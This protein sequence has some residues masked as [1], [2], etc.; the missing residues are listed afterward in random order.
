MNSEQRTAVRMALKGLGFER[1]TYTD[2]ID[3][4]GA[5]NE[6]WEHQGTNPAEVADIIKIEWAPRGPKTLIEVLA[7]MDE[8]RC[9]YVS[10]D[11][12][13]IGS[14]YAKRADG[15]RCGENRGHANGHVL[16]SSEGDR[17]L[18]NAGW[19]LPA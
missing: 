19:T 6:T 3:A 5:Y 9:P 14:A 10:N 8:Q 16:Y 12:M 4:S 17:V 1:T 2:D 18:P 7:E 13:W 15:L 11:P